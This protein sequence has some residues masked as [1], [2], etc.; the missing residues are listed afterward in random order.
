MRN[1]IF[2]MA[3]ALGVAFIQSIP[4][5]PSQTLWEKA[6]VAYYAGQ[7]NETLRALGELK[8]CG[9]KLSPRQQAK[10]DRLEKRINELLDRSFLRRQIPGTSR[11]LPLINPYQEQRW[12]REKIQ[13][14]IV[15]A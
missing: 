10:I 15:P 4:A 3:L 9:E 11:K 7:P 12:K 1:L 13:I 2:L 8:E 14:I 6:V 5:P